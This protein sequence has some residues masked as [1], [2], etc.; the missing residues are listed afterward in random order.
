MSERPFMQLYVSDFIG[1]TL[2]LSAEGVGAYML[3]LM[4]MWNAGGSLPADDPK[5]ARIARM[6]VKKWRA[7]AAEIMP[8]FDASDGVIRHNRLTKE[9]EKSESKSQSRAAAGAEG[10][11]AKALKDQ[12][13]SLANATQMPQHLPDTRSQKEEKP[14]PS[15]SSKSGTR[16]PKGQRVPEEWQAWARSTFRGA[17]PAKL[18][19]ETRQFEDYWPS[20]SGKA[21]VKADWEQTYRVWMRKAFGSFEVVAPAEVHADDSTWQKRLAFARERASWSTPQWGPRPGLSGC[22]APPHLL[23]PGDGEGWSE[24]K[25]VA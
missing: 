23:E 15:A 8:Y 5:L 24:W 19:A 17:E 4:A 25:E 1:D 20:P 11:R 16:W 22:R 9:L 6:S 10:G 14:K 21:G 18:A 2:A 12:Q 7:L 3:L 13:S